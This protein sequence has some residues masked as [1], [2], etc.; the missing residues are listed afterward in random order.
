MRRN[1]KQPNKRGKKGRHNNKRKTMR[2]KQRTSDK[3]GEDKKAIM[4][5]KRRGCLDKTPQRKGIRT[6]AKKQQQKKS[7]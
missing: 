7:E 3:N 4:K 6:T 5:D 1:K 2:R